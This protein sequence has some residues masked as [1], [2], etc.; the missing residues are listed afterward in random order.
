[1]E[2]APALG[3]VRSGMS[4]SSNASVSLDGSP[5]RKNTALRMVWHAARAVYPQP[6]L[7]GW[8]SRGQFAAKVLAHRQHWEPLVSASR[9]SPL[10]WVQTSRPEVIGM[11]VWPYIHNEWSVER[12]FAAFFEHHRMVQPMRWLDMPVG[13]RWV[14]QR[15]DHL[16]PDWSLQ[17]DRPLWL[18]REGE[19]AISLFVG[20]FRAY[21][22]A[23]SLGQVNGR[24]V[25]YVGGI[26]GR[27]V[28]GVND[29]YGQLTKQC[30]GCRP[31]DLLVAV[32]QFLCEAAQVQAI[33][34]ISDSHRHHRHP[35]FAG[36]VDK[37]TMASYDEIWRDRGG[38][39]R[40]D[41]FFALSSRFVPRDMT[42]VPAKK[43]AQYRRRYELLAQIQQRIHDIGQSNMACT[44][45]VSSPA[46]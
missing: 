40:D 41:G 15:L 42:E 6:S 32:L 12:R 7:S 19:L 3:S 22:I 24:T 39:L 35:Y 43:R 17:L 45:I 20:H 1:M 25:A 44:D 9:G 26:Q 11:S 27:S 33:H 13:P 37:I 34:A 4:M 8:V 31:R 2:T 30:H 46:T 36:K 10:S 14:L 21:S 38:C 29:L 23:F 18:F 5:N 28:E 16:H